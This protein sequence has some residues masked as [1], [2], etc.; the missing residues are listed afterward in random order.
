MRLAL[1]EVAGM[2]DLSAVY[3][4]TDVAEVK[5]LAMMAKRHKCACAYTLHS[6]NLL[7]KEF[8]AGESEVRMSGV[9]SFRRLNH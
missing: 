4:D 5:A 3:A 9:I 2:V 8:L 1:R 6:Y 7:L